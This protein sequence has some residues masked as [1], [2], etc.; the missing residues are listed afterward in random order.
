MNGVAIGVYD[1]FD[2]VRGLVDIVRENWDEDYYITIC[3]NHPDPEPH[4]GDVDF[5]E[6][7]H[8]AQIEYP[9][10]GDYNLGCRIQDTIKRASRAAIDGGCD[11]VM[12]VHADAWPLSEQRF[13]NLADRLERRDN[14]IAVRGRGLEFRSPDQWVGSVVDQLFMFDANRA[15]DLEVFEYDPWEMFPDTSISN[16]LTIRFVGKYGLS[17]IDFYSRMDRDRHWDGQ[18]KEYGWLRP[19]VYEPEWETL[20]VA[21]EAFPES[22]GKAVQAIYL[23]RAGLTEGDY[24]GGLLA[25][26][27]APEEEVFDDLEQIERWQDDRLERLGF[28]PEYFGRNFERKQEVLDLPRSEKARVA[29]TTRLK[30]LYFVVLGL[31]YEYTP[32]SDEINPKRLD[33]DTRELHPRL[34]R[35][36]LWPEERLA[37]RYEANYYPDEFPEQI[38]EPWFV[39]S[40]DND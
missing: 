39:D 34:Y 12:Y 31:L 27:D 24:V 35:E 37:E 2:D 19:F 28:K 4:L 30:R 40:G 8:G 18:S 36:A 20:H 7:V 22:Y 14:S 13:C 10:D 25:E 9:S 16:G 11:K 15:R 33:R 3:S 26:H 38:S 5:D 17:E 32:L 29:V 6:L 23:R 21:R 1:K